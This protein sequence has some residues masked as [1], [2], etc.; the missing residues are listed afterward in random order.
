MYQGYSLS[1]TIIVKSRPLEHYFLSIFSLI[2]NEEKEIIL[3][4]YGSSIGKTIDIVNLLTGKILP[5][6][7]NVIMEPSISNIDV[8]KSRNKISVIKIILTV[9]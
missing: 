2:L 1:N 4:S 7:F 8:G 5:N 9:R 6:Y 3:K